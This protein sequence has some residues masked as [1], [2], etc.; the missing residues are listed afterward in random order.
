MKSMSLV[1][2]LLLGSTLTIAAD[3]SVEQTLI[4][5]EKSWAKA[6]EK[7]DAKAMDAVLA[8]AF[9]SV[10]P[11]GQLLDKKQYIDAR[12][13][14]PESID[15]SSLEDMKVRVHGN[16][17]TVTGRYVVKGKLKQ[18]SVSHEYR[19]VDTFISQNG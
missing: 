19:W 8:D 6:I 13:K 18:E 2:A 7:K 4:A 12:L 10:E 15:S 17:A 16:A 9:V 5:L 14:D 11:D 1:I 3:D